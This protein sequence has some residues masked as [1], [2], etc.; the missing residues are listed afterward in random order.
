MADNDFP[1]IGELVLVKVKEILKT[2]V[3]VNLEKY[4]KTGVIS[5]SEVAP[6]RIRNIRDYVVVKKKVICKVLRVDKTTGHIDLS[7]RRVTQ[8]ETREEMQKYKNE[9]VAM[10]ILEMILKEKAR[11]I[12]AKIK[13]SYPL[14]HEFFEASLSNPDVLNKFLQKE[15]AEKILTIIT[16]KMKVKKIIARATLSISSTAPNGLSVIKD[17]L[18]KQKDVKIVYIGAPH[19]MLTAEDENPKV[20]H[21]RLDTAIESITEILKKANGK[22]EVVKKE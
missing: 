19:Y 4:G 3:F 17:A 21:K 1:E 11:D 16:D 5:T 13:E 8:K 18:K 10:K 15:D 2:T 7:L 20:T 9:E 14:L 22:V 12:S 6:G